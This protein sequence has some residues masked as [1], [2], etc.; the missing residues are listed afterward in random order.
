MKLFPKFFLVASLCAVLPLMLLGGAALWRLDALRTELLGA[1]VQTSRSTAD[2]GEQALFR[3]SSRL[4][5]QVV[6]R[7]GEELAEFYE[8]VRRL[9]GLQTALARRY[10]SWPAA[11][12]GT[13]LWSDTRMAELLADPV[14]SS[15][16]LRKV[17]YAIYH[18]APGTKPELAQDS[19]DRLGRLG[20]YYASVHREHPWLKSLYLAHKDGF[21]LGYPG[22]KP[23]PDDYDPRTRD[24]YTKAVEKK[25]VT[26]TNVYLDKDKRPI[27][28]CAEPV[29]DGDR[30]I[31]VSAAD[32]SMD[33]FL[34][35]LF[36]LSELPVTDA[37]L[38]NYLG[39]IR[40][41]AAAEPDGR[42]RWRSWPPETSP[43]VG[44]YLDGRLAPAFKASLKNDSGYL[45]TDADGRPVADL[46]DAAGGDLLSYSRIFIRTRKEGKFWYYLVRTPV[47]RITGPAREV[48]GILSGLQGQLAGAIAG[49]T[50]TIS[51]LIAIVAAL[52]LL[53]AFLAAGLGARALS[54][55]LARLALAVRR[56]GAG[57]FE[58]HM[59]DAGRDEVGEVSRAVNEMVKGLK[60]GLFVKNSF[61][62]YLAASVVD[63]LIKDPD[64]LKL[65]GEDRELT[66]FFSDMSGFTSFSE[67]MEPQQLVGLI[68]EYLT[69]MTDSIFLQ[70]GTLDKYEGDAVMAFWG[71]PVRQEDHA[72]R[73][74]WAALD[75]R[76]RLK[77]LCLSWQQR[78]LP[79]FD[80]RIGINTGNMI[81]G[82]IGSTVRMDYTVLGDAVN[83]ASRMEQANKLYGTHIMISE[84]TRRGAGGAVD[85]RE[86]D[87]LE[88]HG[89][90][91]ALRVFELLGLTGQVPQERMRG[92]RMYEEALAAYRQR[93]WD[94][95]ER[96]W[97]DVLGILGED[98]ASRVMLE[99]VQAFRREPPPEN[100]D[101]VY[102]ATSK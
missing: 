76:S 50:R 74:C 58:V 56:V 92:Y 8:Q 49:Q 86:L 33:S 41:A 55:P 98:R 85:A 10:L 30:L 24:W 84:A 77:E 16:T 67:H 15:A 14:F 29:F 44:K 22:S 57:D 64:R 97:N 96:L 61:K 28:S 60:E 89:K 102:H 17:P 1:S 93:R 83:T 73:A 78:G 52:T 46:R 99:R 71:A 34:D 7:R 21:I 37:M 66:V 26:W 95:A 35:R 101:G 9:V 27:I 38:V 31:G 11:G 36:D 12:T 54:L 40:I 51:V 5:V 70:E 4:H 25:R 87:L 82:N 20:E 72:R 53:A 18:L 63:Q 59:R 43:L 19:L 65:G 32:V 69:A 94:E 90:K 3:E 6:E 100:W 2:A 88:L 39:R 62:R 48:R 75:N 81:V 79:V 13:P 47:S 23:F 68:N 45:L 80:I 91:N 42:L